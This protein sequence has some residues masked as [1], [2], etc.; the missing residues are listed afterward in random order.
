LWADPLTAVVLICQPLEVESL[1]VQ[2]GVGVVFDAALVFAMA[3]VLSL[4]A[5]VVVGSMG[6]AKTLSHAPAKYN[7]SLVGFV[8]A[9]VGVYVLLFGQ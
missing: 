4:S 8:I 6:I 2:A 7:D 1:A 9:A 3:S 5:L